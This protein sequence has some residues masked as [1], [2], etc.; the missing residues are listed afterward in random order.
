[1][2]LLRI[3]KPTTRKGKQVLLNREP[4]LLENA[5][6]TLI[7]EG[8][9]C[10]GDIKAALKDL[11]NLKKPLAKRLSR[12]NEITPFE[13]EIPLQQLAEKNECSMFMFGSTSKKRPNNLILGRLYEKELLDMVELGL[14]KYRGLQDFKNEKITEN[15]K[16]C[17]V[18]NGP[19]WTQSDEIRRLKCL[20]IDAF[21]RE[22]VE[23]LRLQ[24]MEHVLSFTLTEDMTLL[25]RSYKILLKKS[26]QKTPRIELMEIG[27]ACDFVI[28]RTKIASQD[29]YK[30]ARKRPKQLKTLKKKNLSTDVFGNKHGQVHLGK[31]NIHKIQTR[32]VKALKKVMEERKAEKLNGNEADSAEEE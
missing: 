30:L 21:H 14:V 26:G 2:S 28:R 13:D 25:M 19:K 12:S 27:P 18:F 32:K 10:S 24:G 17:L 3:R 29:L 4:K 5:K 23:S 1:M 6:N 20:L 31:Q 15:V 16:P 11:Y 9:K 7:L 8:R 22:T